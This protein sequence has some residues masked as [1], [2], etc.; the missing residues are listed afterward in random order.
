MLKLVDPTLNLFTY[1]LKKGLGVEE[2]ET[3]K[4][5]GRFLDSLSKLLHKKLNV[6]FTPNKNE[7]FWR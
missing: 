2:S 4:T 1:T 5:Y 7:S 3:R 6:S